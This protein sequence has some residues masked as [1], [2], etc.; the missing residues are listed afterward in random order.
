MHP[1]RFSYLAYNNAQPRKI[2]KAERDNRGCYYELECGHK[3]SS[4][5]HFSL[6]KLGDTRRCAK[7]GEAFV[8]SSPRY[9]SEFAQ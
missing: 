1:S 2:V 3:S 9:A 4:A 8:K 6:A 7:C 5:P